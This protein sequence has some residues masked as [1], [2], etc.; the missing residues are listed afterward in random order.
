MKKVVNEYDCVLIL[1]DLLGNWKTYFA[2]YGQETTI[3]GS[4]YTIVQDDIGHRALM[5][6]KKPTSTAPSRYFQ[7]T[8]EDIKIVLP[9]EQKK[10]LQRNPEEELKLLQSIVDC[11]VRVSITIFIHIEII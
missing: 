2:P 8:K 3:F 4:L 5:H 10:P 7:G 9:L 6:R 11:N 1:K